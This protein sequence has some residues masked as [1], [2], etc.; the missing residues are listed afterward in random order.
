MLRV[1]DMCSSINCITI[2][3]DRSCTEWCQ[4]MSYFLD[5]DLKDALII[6]GALILTGATLG[7]IFHFWPAPVNNSVFITNK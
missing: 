6:V 5:D 7:S 4:Q 1:R 3:T 2:F